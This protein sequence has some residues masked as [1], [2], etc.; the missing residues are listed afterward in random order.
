MIG[1]VVDPAGDLS[2]LDEVRAAVSGAGMVPL[3]VAPHGGKLP[4]GTTVQRSF[5]ATRSVEFDAVIVA[6]CPV[7]APDAVVAR[8]S[9]AGEESAPQLDPRVVLLLQECFRHAKAIGA[10]GAGVSALELAGVGDAPGVVVG[11]DP[12]TV[13]AELHA[14]LGAHRVWERF[15]TVLG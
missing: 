9:K 13:V 15:E 14:T 2:G 10:W 5:G 4:D 11:D 3:I 6:G 8:D 7:P 1:I 12:A